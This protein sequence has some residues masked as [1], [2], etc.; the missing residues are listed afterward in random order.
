MFSSAPIGEHCRGELE[1]SLFSS[2]IQKLSKFENPNHAITFKHVLYL[3]NPWRITDV[4]MRFFEVAVK[5]A[6]FP[7]VQKWLFFYKLQKSPSGR[8]LRSQMSFMMHFKRAAVIQH[9]GCGTN[10][11]IDKC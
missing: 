11:G 5:R 8:E 10:F 6:K 7:E 4:G 3:T 1:A 2:V 9:I